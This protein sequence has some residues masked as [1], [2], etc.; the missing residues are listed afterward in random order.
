MQVS[1]SSDS[2]APGRSGPWAGYA[3][4]DAEAAARANAASWTRDAED[5]LAE[6]GAALGAADFVWGPEGL[7]EEDARLLGPV[8]DLRGATVVELGAGAAQCSRWL[9]A[10][11]VQAI[12]TDVS[13]GMLAASRSLDAATGIRTPTLL[14]DAR[15]LPLPDRS[16]DAV[17]TSFGAIPFVGDAERVHA[18]AA[19]LLRPGGRWVCSVTHP[20]RWMFPDDPTTT[21]MTVTRPYFDRRPYVETDSGGV[22]YA[23]FHRTVGDHVRDVVSAGL[24]LVDVVEP[25]WPAGRDVTWGGW[26]PERGAFVPGTM[27]LVARRPASGPGA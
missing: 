1:S 25:E 2:S 8:E 21:G 16:A 15:S 12:A 23:E 27:I 9:T 26:G 5:Y 14:A 17:F 3:D 22:T 6:H 19:R 11:G 18:E 24:E 20:V 13:W 7:R 4:V 10:R